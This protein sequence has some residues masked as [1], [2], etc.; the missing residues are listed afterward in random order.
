MIYAEAV[1]LAESAAG[2]EPAHP[3]SSWKQT[4]PYL[5]L[6]GFVWEVLAPLWKPGAVCDP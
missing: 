1:G 5:L 3:V 2:S 4:V 6:C